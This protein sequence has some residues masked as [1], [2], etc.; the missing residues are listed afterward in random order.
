MGKINSKF[1]YLFYINETIQ[2][3]ADVL[4]FNSTP[5]HEWLNTH[6]YE[7]VAQAQKLATLWSW[8]YNNKLL[9]L[10]LVGSRPLMYSR[11]LNEYL[12]YNYGLL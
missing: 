9:N 8:I 5:R 10:Q 3:N 4:Q 2:H 7:S 1:S 12:R 11:Q 6:M